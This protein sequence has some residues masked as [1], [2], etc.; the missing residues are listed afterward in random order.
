MEE[1]TSF[2]SALE[3]NKKEV[4]DQFLKKLKEK[5]VEIKVISDSYE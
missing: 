4:E 3:D 5:E 1:M 2:I